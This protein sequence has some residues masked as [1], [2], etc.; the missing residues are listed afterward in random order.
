MGLS[1]GLCLD[2][3]WYPFKNAVSPAD[4]VRGL[5]MD[6]LAYNLP[7]WISP[8]VSE[9][10]KI[11]LLWGKNGLFYH[12]LVLCLPLKVSG[13]VQLPMCSKAQLSLVWKNISFAPG[14]LLFCSVTWH[15]TLSSILT[16]ILG[17]LTSGKFA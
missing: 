10:E 12:L 4:S 1:L 6:I 16:V 5:M 3:L 7:V 17:N 14:A 13:F 15:N 11:T 9:S 2:I 8:L